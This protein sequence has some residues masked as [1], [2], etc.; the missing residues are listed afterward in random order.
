MV[1]KIYLLAV[2][3]IYFGLAIWCSVS[4]TTT[5]QKVG[6]AI[7]GGSG[8]SEFMTVYGGLE[9]GIACVFALGVVRSE[10]VGLAV[11][12]CVIIHGALVL[13]RSM[14]FFMFRDIDSFTYKLAAGEWLITILGVAIL[15]GARSKS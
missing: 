4:P 3:S 13:F 2:A 6:L 12:A 15:I 11:L 14:S 10:T 9:F 5:S 8:Q 7:K 1:A